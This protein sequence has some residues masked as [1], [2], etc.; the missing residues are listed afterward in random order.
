MILVQAVEIRSRERHY[1]QTSRPWQC[2]CAEAK[3]FGGLD[4][5][6][7]RVVPAWRDYRRSL[8]RFVCYNQMVENDR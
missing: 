4:N 8:K 5:P 7:V 2:R 6:L 1:L 3:D